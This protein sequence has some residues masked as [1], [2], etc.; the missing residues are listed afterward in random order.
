MKRFKDYRIGVRLNVTLSLIFI[1]ILVLFGVYAINLQQKNVFKDTDTRMF[2]QV[3]DLAIIIDRELKNRQLE[4]DNALK[5]AVYILNS[6]GQ[7]YTTDRVRDLVALDQDSKKNREVKIQ[8]LYIGQVSLY[9]N[10]EIVDKITNMTHTNTTIFQKIDGG[11]LRIASN[12]LKADGTRAINTYIPNSSPVVQSI[13]N[14]KSFKGRAMVMDQWFLTS[15]HPLKVNGVI[16]GMI[17]VGTPEN[18]ME[19]LKAIFLN[20]KYFESGYPYLVNKDGVFVIHP[21][22]EGKNVKE[23]TF[24]QKMLET[25]TTEPKS[26]P[27]EWEG[28]DKIQYFKYIPAIESYVATTIYKNEMMDMI[29]KVFIAIVIAILIG[30]SLFIFI[31]SLIIRSVVN[32]LKNGIDFSQQIA[33]GN[34][35][36]EINIDQKDEVGQ[37]AGALSLMSEKLREIVLNI[38]TGA[39]NIVAASSQISQGSQ[40]MSQGANE[41]ASSTE[42]ISSSMEEMVSNIQQNTDNS[43]QTEK[44]S[45]KTAQSMEAMNQS[46]RKSLESI[47]TIAEKITIIND[48]AFQTNLLALNAAVEAARAGEHGKGFAV[49][50]AEV[51]KLAERSKIAADE[52]QTISKDSIKITEETTVLLDALLPE[53]QKTTL[54]VKEIASSSLEQNSGADQINSAIQQL[55]SVT[56]QNAASSEELA[57]SSEELAAQADSLLQLVAFFQIDDEIIKHK[58]SSVGQTKKQDNQTKKFGK[59]SETKPKVELNIMNRA[60][61]DSDFETF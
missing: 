2:E 22:N 27:Y 50:A 15:Y 53:F 43:K 31:N 55:N 12:I 32:K 37:L 6:S 26:M 11:Y 40:Q 8:E 29:R 61:S 49:V 25:K 58:I 3:N 5:T 36:A 52:I 17:F 30:S 14:D 48:I 57:T 34:L 23:Y 60:S 41:Q 21:T 44:I 19:G 42:E 28:K 59:I 35:L 46:G 51:R 18:D 9:N 54:L 39:D 4:V 45:A 10:N 7:I 13:E 24:I 33:N 20:K 47:K 16:I 56:Q 38:R 1:I